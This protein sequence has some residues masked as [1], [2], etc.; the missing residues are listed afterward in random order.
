MT[1]DFPRVADSGL[2]GRREAAFAFCG[3]LHL[4]PGGVYASVQ[5]VQSVQNCNT[6][7]DISI[8]PAWVEAVSRRFAFLRD[9]SDEERRWARHSR[10][11]E[12]EVRQA[13]VG[14]GTSS[15]EDSLRTDS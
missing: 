10:A 6:Y 14:L 2:R 5:R 3:A 11:D 9:L 4:A 1:Y 15:A 12:W 13:I 7:L 8:V